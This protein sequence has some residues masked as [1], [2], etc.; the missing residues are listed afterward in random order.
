MHMTSFGRE[1]IGT[2]TPLVS[3]G[4]VVIDGVAA[5]LALFPRGM[6]IIEGFGRVDTQIL[7]E[8]VEIAVW[9]SLRLWLPSDK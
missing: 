9:G 2:I 7:L 6:L 3:F 1:S 8:R 5:L 4:S